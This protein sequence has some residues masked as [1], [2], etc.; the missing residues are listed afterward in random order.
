MDAEQ[1]VSKILSEA[2][3]QADAITGEAKD[4]CAAEQA[5]LTE[6]MAAYNKETETLADE[7]GADKKSR[8][9]AGA[10]MQLSKEYLAAKAV[11]LDKVFATAA[12]KI[13]SLSDSKYTE[14]M[15]GLM[16]KAVETGDETV[17]P[18]KDDSRVDQEVVKQVNRKL[19][20]GFKG[21]LELSSEKANI[22]GGFILQR[23]NVKTNV[24]IEVLISSA[25]AEL[26]MEIAEQMF[27]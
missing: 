17:I 12:E 3:S 2:Q 16:E 20:P 6:E 4:K 15:V 25:R 9:L 19:G 1:V 27:G 5:S 10:R 18:G 24:S 22:A 21:K 23:G 7:A 14:L 11:L 26:E 8:M 13:K